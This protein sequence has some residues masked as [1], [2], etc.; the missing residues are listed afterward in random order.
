MEE[1]MNKFE[2]KIYKECCEYEC[3]TSELIQKYMVKNGNKV[4]IYLPKENIKVTIKRLSYPA[5]FLY[6]D[7]SITVYLDGA[8]GEK[9]TQWFNSKKDKDKLIK[10]IPIIKTA[11]EELTNMAEC[12]T[13]TIEF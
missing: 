4:D 8:L 2:I 7:G 12:K 13:F 5:I 1:N 9:N 6:S 3:Q 10:A 11:L